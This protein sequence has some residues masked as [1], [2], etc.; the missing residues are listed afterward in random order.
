MDV[1]E[2]I[3]TRRSIR[4]FK[5]DPVPKELVDKMLKAAMQAPSAGNR[6]PWHYVV[7]T[8][9]EKLDKVPE[10]HDYSKMIKEAPLAILV[11][12]KVTHDKYCDYWVQDCSAATENLLLAAHG[13]GLGAVWLGI[14]PRQERVTGLKDLLKL[15]GDIIPLSLNVIGYSNE[16]KKPA[17]R[18]DTERIH[19]N[20]W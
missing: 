1:M 20:Q 12:A 4:K 5:K 15:P 2:A 16:E 7:I 10:F 6:Q 11:C 13:L 19:Y 18:F 9:R 3:M 17:D 8:D 14:Y